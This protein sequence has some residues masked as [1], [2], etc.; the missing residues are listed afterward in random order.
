M[1]GAADDEDGG[2]D[3]HDDAMAA[4]LLADVN[5]DAKTDDD[6]GYSKKWKLVQEERKVAKGTLG[7]RSCPEEKRR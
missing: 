3:G 4:A 5:E 6:E 7:V 1:A 2:E